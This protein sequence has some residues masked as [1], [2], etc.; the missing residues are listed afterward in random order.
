MIEIDW[1]EG[2]GVRRPVIKRGALTA[3]FDPIRIWWNDRL[4]PLSPTEAG[5][6]ALVM[7]RSRLCWAEVN[8]ALGSSAPAR[9]V[10][11]HRIRHKVA[12]LGGADPVETIRHWGVRL[13]VEEDREHSRTTWIGIDEAGL[14]LLARTGYPTPEVA[15]MSKTAAAA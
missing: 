1:P 11:L 3:T 5:L 14:R 9:A 4:I 15:K 10:L 7:R 8:E 13:R 2:D 12:E 6:L